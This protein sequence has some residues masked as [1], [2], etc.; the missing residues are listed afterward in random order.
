ML[1]KKI[2]KILFFT[3]PIL[4]GGVV[5]THC[6]VQ[7]SG[8]KDLSQVSKEDVYVLLDINDVKI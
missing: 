2:I 8:T 4:F 7:N 1:L 5:I 6:S 3:L